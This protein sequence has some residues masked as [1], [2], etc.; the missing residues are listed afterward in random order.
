MKNDDDL[1]L[2]L[3]FDAEPAEPED[4]MDDDILLEEESTTVSFTISPSDMD[5]SED[6][7][8]SA[9]A[10]PPSRPRAAKPAAKKKP[11][12]KKKVAKARRAKPAKAAK[13]KPAAKKPAKK[14]AAKAKSARKPAPKKKAKKAMYT[15]AKESRKSNSSPP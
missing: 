9:P 13:K 4:G 11:V 6:E 8:P 14:K 12:K 1:D 2:G 15:G 3:D 10:A 7:G 5:E